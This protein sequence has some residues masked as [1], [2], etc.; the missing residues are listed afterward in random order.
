M[1]FVNREALQKYLEL[2]HAPHKITIM[3]ISEHKDFFNVLYFLDDKIAD[4]H[5]MLGNPKEHPDLMRDT[6]KELEKI[7]NDDV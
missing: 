4:F 3:V 6:D 5:Y 1:T 2:K 7:L